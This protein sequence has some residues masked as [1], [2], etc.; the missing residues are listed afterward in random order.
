MDCRLLGSSL[1][2]ILQASVLE[3]VAISFCRGSSRPRDRTWVPWIPGR[4]FNFW[5]TIDTAKFWYLV[6]KLLL[7]LLRV[8]GWTEESGRRQSMGLLRVGHETSLWLFTFMHWRRKWQPTPE[9][10]PG[11]SQGW[12][13]LVGCRLWIAQ[14]RTRLKWRS[15]SSSSNYLRLCRQRTF[16]STTCNTKA[17]INNTWRSSSVPAKLYV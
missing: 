17:I 12:G 8:C 1:H 14:S 16:V 6:S 9:F 7:L 10:L 3:W 5:A 13:S 4:R 15:S 11:E 2:G